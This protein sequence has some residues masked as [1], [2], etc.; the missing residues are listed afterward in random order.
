M[1][2]DWGR[3]D[4]YRRI[5]G[6]AG[7]REGA[8]HDKDM[9]ALCCR[10]K[11]AEMWSRVHHEDLPRTQAA[12]TLLQPCASCQREIDHEAFERTMANIDR[13]DRER[14]Q[15]AK[16]QAQKDAARAAEIEEIRAELDHLAVNHLTSRGFHVEVGPRKP[17][18][19]PPRNPGNPTTATWA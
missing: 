11:A 16:E 18:K 10:W 17:R 7:V 14:K 5:F 6:I 8:R 13:L 1:Q 3:S 2:L 12:L 19:P 15:R 4:E 9:G